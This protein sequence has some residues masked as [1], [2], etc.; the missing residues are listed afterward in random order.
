MKKSLAKNE[1]VVFMRKNPIVAT[2]AMIVLVI[3][4]WF[5]LQA[6][7]P[8][9]T[10]VDDQTDTSTAQKT[11]TTQTAGNNVAKASYVEAL[12]TYKDRRMQFDQNCSAVPTKTT[13]RIGTKFMLD[14]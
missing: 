4:V 11:T 2:V 3:L 1:L 5:G 9:L 12:Q 14:N 13:Y 8:T 7:V 6:Q 10:T